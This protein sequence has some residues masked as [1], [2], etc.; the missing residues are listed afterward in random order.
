[1]THQQLSLVTDEIVDCLAYLFEDGFYLIVCIICQKV[2]SEEGATTPS[3]DMT[4][5]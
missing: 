2:V 1:M 5:A 4:G 3:S